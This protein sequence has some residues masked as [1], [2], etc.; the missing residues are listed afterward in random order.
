MA[1][2]WHQ[3]P[4]TLPTNIITKEIN[5]STLQRHLL[6]L[7]CTPW[8]IKFG[9]LCMFALTL[10]SAAQVLRRTCCAPR[11][12]RASCWLMCRTTSDEMKCK[13]AAAIR[14][15]FQASISE[16]CWVLWVGVLVD[17]ASLVHFWHFLI[18]VSQLSTRNCG[19][20]SLF[21]AQSGH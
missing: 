19:R 15:S 12:S 8:S 18:R 10:H 9:P 5:T 11:G 2:S 21:G 20:L 17:V 14:H 6:T 16:Y 4:R 3:N 7:T 1:A 13:I